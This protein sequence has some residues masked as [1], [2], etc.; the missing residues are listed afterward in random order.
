MAASKIDEIYIQNFKFFPELKEPIK[1]GGN[2]LLLYGENGSGKSSIY[3]A[4]YTLLECANKTDDNEI[5]KYF[6]QNPAEKQRLVNINCPNTID[7]FIKIK[8]IDGT[9]FNVSFADTSINKKQEAQESNY[10]SDFIT[11]RNLLSLYN[12]AHSEEINLTRFFFNA[13]LPY[14]KFQSILIGGNSIVNAGRMV[15]IINQGLQKNVRDLPNIEPRYP[16]VDEKSYIEYDN[17]IDKFKEELEKLLVFINTKGNQIL[18]DELK[19]DFTFSLSLE[20]VVKEYSKKKDNIPQFV[21]RLLIPEY[22]GKHNVVFRPHSFLNE[23]R[24]TALGLAIRLAIL[25]KTLSSD[26]KLN[27]LVLDDLL[28]SLDMS[29]RNKVIDMVLNDYQNNYQVLFLTHDKL[30][31]DLVK[32]RLEQNKYNDW[33]CLEMYVDDN[34]NSPVILPSESFYAKACFHLSKYDYPASGNYFRKACEEIFEKYFPREVSIGNDGQKR[35]QLKNYIDAAIKFYERLGLNTDKINKLDNYLI[36]LMNP[37]SHRAIDTNIYK[38]ELNDIKSL[39]PEIIKETQDYKFKE[40]IAEKG[41]LVVKFSLKPPNV[42]E[43]I[44]QT[45]EPI[46]SYQVG[47][48]KQISNSSC[49][50]K[51]ST[52]IEL[53]GT[54]NTS[55][56]ENYKKNNIINI[57]KAIYEFKVVQYD[58]SYM[59]NIY[60]LNSGLKLKELDSQ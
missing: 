11:Y 41:N 17:L 19:Y 51:E 8:F 2:H 56:N 34:N 35:K 28:I 60:E 43:Y 44:I 20:A 57:H 47:G 1:L 29:N 3:W 10:S 26:S 50:S 48:Q 5:K 42:Y 18:K 13:I 46:Y 31:F 9:D 52:T 6:N 22:S 53:N 32:I 30:L 49:K 24:L 4:L 39:I 59:E 25:E 37:L 55:K 54:K 15:A 16:H 58:D 40:L 14:V 45:E 23:A 12:F 21:V 7:S 36:L 38:T 33:T 27:L